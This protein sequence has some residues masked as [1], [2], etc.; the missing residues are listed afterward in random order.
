M[1]EFNWYKFDLINKKIVE[2]IERIEE[3]E[4]FKKSQSKKQEIKLDPMLP[5]IDY[6]I[7]YIP[8]ENTNIIQLKRDDERRLTW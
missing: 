3:L 6:G 2:I 5:V 1:S 4:K 7:P 8:Q